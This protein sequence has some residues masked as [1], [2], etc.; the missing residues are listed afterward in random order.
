MDWAIESE[1]YRRYDEIEGWVYTLDDHEDHIN[2]SDD[3]DFGRDDYLDNEPN[4][5]DADDEVS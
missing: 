1:F 2:L 5:N 3:T 4:E